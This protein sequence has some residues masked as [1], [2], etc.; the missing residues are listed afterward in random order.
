VIL[1]LSALYLAAHGF[2]RALGF[3]SRTLR[4]GGRNLHLYDRAGEGSAPPV[5]LVHGL[6]GNAYSFTPLLRTCVRACS[7]VVAIEL[8][9]HGRSPL[10]AADEPATMLECAQAVAAALLEIDG[11]AVLVGSSLGGAIALHTAIALPEKVAGVVGLNPAGAPLAGADRLAV[12][13]AFRGGSAKAA[14]ETNRRL[15]RQPPR[16]GWLFARDLGRHW[17]SRPVRRLT[18]ELQQ[19]QPGIAPEL[20]AQLEQPVLIL[21]GDS[22]RILPPSSVDYFRAHL[23]AGAVEIVEGS[24][25]LPQLEKAA[26]V[27]ARVERFIGEL[28]QHRGAS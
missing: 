15:Y 21:W 17:A 14:L 24:G 10:P 20:L 7:R 22:D 8:P 3:R 1:P 2:Y 19:D 28:E 9:G 16:L 6:G 5:L 4:A 23:K 11:P 12:L 18:E 26:L 27:A 25:H 13:E